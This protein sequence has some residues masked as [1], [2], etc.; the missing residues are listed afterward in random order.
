LARF[1]EVGYSQIFTTSLFYKLIL[2]ALGGGTFA[3]VIYC[4]LKLPPSR[5]PAFDSRRPPTSS[6]FPA[7]SHRPLL[8][9]LL[10]PGALLSV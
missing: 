9:R 10:L 5:R 6:S 2:G 1:Q 7:G 3:A 4:N 8:K